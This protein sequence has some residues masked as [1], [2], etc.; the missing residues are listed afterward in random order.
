VE[1]SAR[2][3]VRSSHQLRREVRSFVVRHHPHGAGVADDDAREPAMTRRHAEPLRDRRVERA[4]HEVTNEIPVTHDELESLS[5]TGAY[6]L[7]VRCV[8]ACAVLAA[9]RG[10][11]LVAFDLRIEA[12]AKEPGVP[13]THAA[14]LMRDDVRGLARA[15][16]GARPDDIEAE[17]LEVLAGEAGL[18]ATERRELTARLG[19]VLSM[20]QE[21][22][23]A[24]RQGKEA[25][26]YLKE[27]AG[28][29]R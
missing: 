22:E 18:L 12:F 16:E 28:G 23:G 26:L 21:N 15:R 5:A 24:S 4:T 20:P 6:D 1:E 7:G 27:E 9:L 10:R 2:T 25:T 14:E 11:H 13:D 3:S 8:S 17:G 29:S 19:L